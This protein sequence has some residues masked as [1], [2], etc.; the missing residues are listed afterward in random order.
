MNL[1]AIGLQRRG[2]VR[3]RAGV[4]VLQ[5]VAPGLGGLC[6]GKPLQKQRVRL[7]HAVGERDDHQRAVPE[8]F[9]LVVLYQ[10]VAHVAR[11]A[12]VG[13]R[14]P[15]LGQFAHQKVHAYLL[16]L[17]HLEE[18]CQLAARYLDHANNARRDLG[19]THAA[20]VTGG[21]VDL[22]GLGAGHLTGN[23]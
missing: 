22:D 12:D 8:V 3:L 17:G 6:Y 19:H 13:A 2:G 20:R 9:V 4:A 14:Q 16:S 1:V 15:R 7:R 21:E 5:A 18:V 11:L 10:P 23:R